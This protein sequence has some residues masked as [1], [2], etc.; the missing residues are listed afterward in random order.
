MITIP[1]VYH[2][3]IGDVHLGFGI[4]FGNQPHVALYSTEEERLQIR[5]LD[6]AIIERVASSICPGHTLATILEFSVCRGVW[7]AV[8]LPR[9]YLM[10]AA[11]QHNPVLRLHLL[12][13]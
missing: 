1:K 5:L 3:I 4:N 9:D 11:G 12:T 6:S 13:L 10:F 8:L 2:G 7:W